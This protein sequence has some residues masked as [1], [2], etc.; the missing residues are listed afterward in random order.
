MI[1]PLNPLNQG[2]I[3]LGSIPSSIRLRFFTISL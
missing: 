1:E 3:S 2:T